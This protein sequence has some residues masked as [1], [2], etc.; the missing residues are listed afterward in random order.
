MNKT[1]PKTIFLKDYSPTPYLIDRVD[2]DVK[3]NAEETLITSKLSFR[4]NPS[5]DARGRALELDGEA[6]ALKGVKINGR[7]A[8][9][10]AYAASRAQADAA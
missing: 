4:R 1:S 9:P 3:L 5:P 2:L 10:G 7:R 8:E 6:I